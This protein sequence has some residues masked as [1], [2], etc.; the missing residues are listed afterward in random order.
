MGMV[1]KQHDFAIHAALLILKAAEFGYQVTL[2]DAYRDDRCA[3]GSPDSF[4]KK[5]LAI[6]L[7]LFRDGIYLTETKDHKPLGE[8][9]KSIGG[10]WGGDFVNADG[11]PN[12]D[13]NHYSW[14]E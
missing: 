12:P 7:N 13:G 11:T 10:T 1:H 4:H 14:G 9:W 3:Y 2:G 8:Y 6:D 5:R